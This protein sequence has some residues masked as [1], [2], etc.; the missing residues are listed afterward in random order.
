M[1]RPKLTPE[2]KLS[3]RIIFRLTEDEWLTLIELGRT[4]GK[5]PGTLVREKLFTGKYPK[6]KT[7]KLDLYTYTELKKI[8]VNLNQLTRKVYTGFLPKELL[9]LL[10]KLLKQ[11]ETI[12]S[13]LV[14]DSQSKDR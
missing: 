13:L 14:Y 9:G 1:A 8:G 4:C 10:M 7:A 11:Q 2:E 3:K 12:I 5:A 6:P